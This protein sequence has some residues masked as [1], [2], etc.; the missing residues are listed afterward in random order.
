MLSHT[1]E[2]GGMPTG[3][4]ALGAAAA[5]AVGLGA[6]PLLRQ[7]LDHKAELGKL[8]K[9]MHQGDFGKNPEPATDAGTPTG[10]SR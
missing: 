7:H 10:L 6:V 1:I 8:K 2:H 4:S 3:R 9:F 5:G